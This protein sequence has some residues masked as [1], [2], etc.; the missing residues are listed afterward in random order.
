MLVCL[1]IDGIPAE[2]TIAAVDATAPVCTFIGGN[3]RGGGFL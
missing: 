2:E 1:C 3:V